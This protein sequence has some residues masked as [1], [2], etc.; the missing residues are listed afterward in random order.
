MVH[1][2]DA[3][4]MTGL[5]V[6]TEMLRLVCTFNSRDFYSRLCI[7]ERPVSDLVKL[8]SPHTSRQEQFHDF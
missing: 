6:Q 7:N 1:V 3:A 5:G 2:I 4:Q 8:K